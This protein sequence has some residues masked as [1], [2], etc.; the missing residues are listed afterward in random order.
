M[1]D[2]DN[3][4]Y[5]NHNR[6]SITITITIATLMRNSPNDSTVLLSQDKKR[7]QIEACHINMS[8]RA[9]STRKHARSAIRRA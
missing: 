5:H 1:Q 4:L 9:T 6:I 2:D 8:H 7:H 3:S